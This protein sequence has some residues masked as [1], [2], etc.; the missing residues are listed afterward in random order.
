MRKYRWHHLFC[1]YIYYFF[2]F[3][4][5]SE[6]KLPNLFFHGTN[7]NLFSVWNIR[8]P[9][10][11][12]NKLFEAFQTKSRIVYDDDDD[13]HII[14]MIIITLERSAER[15][16]MSGNYSGNCTLLLQYDQI[17]SQR[18][19]IIIFSD[20]SITI[21]FKWKCAGVSNL[22]QQHIK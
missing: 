17:K 22:K 1:I 15:D 9:R 6:E 8:Q 21:S 14:I 12:D 5:C 10:K 13:G 16:S 4:N 2:V 20:F 3:Y 18:A 7:D 19:T 11:R